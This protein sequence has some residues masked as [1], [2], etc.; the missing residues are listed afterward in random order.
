MKRRL[1]RSGWQALGTFKPHGEALD[2][3]RHLLVKQKVAKLM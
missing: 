3:W 1:F 2:F